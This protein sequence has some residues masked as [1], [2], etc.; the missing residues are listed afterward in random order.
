MVQKHGESTVFE[1]QKYEDRHEKNVPVN[2]PYEIKTSLF[3][4]FR[5][6]LEELLLLESSPTM[7]IFASTK[8]SCWGTIDAFEQYS[9]QK[10]AMML[11]EE[12]YILSEDD[13]KNSLHSL[14]VL[15]PWTT[16]SCG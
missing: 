6:I 3:S 8:Y 13:I 15:M 11:F 1:W 4:G 16:K 12:Q 5:W 9:R 7:S 14:L 10:P 2:Y